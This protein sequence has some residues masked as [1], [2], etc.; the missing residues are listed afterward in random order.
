MNIILCIYS[1][2]LSIMLNIFISLLIVQTEKVSFIKYFRAKTMINS[3]NQWIL[4]KKKKKVKMFA[5]SS[6]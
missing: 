1:T 5:V 2:S 3:D 6:F 4:Q